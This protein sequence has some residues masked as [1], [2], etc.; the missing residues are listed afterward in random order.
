MWTQGAKGTVYWVEFRIPQGKAHFWGIILN[1]P[2]TCQ[3]SKFSTYLL[4][5][6]ATCGLCLPVCCSN[7][8][9]FGSGSGSLRREISAI[10]ISRRRVFGK[11]QLSGG[12]ANAPH[13]RRTRGWI[14]VARRTLGGTHCVIVVAGLARVSA[15]R[16]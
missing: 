7:L 6:A 8:L 16:H 13:S 11:E 3:Q 10:V 12:G 14:R 15:G 2:Q 1:Y 9:G 4:G 5:A